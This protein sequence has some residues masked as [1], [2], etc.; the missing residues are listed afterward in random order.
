[1]K[2]FAILGIIASVLLIGGIFLAGANIF[3]SSEE[4]TTQTQTSTS[5]SSCPYASEGGCTASNNCGLSSCGATTGGSC[6]CN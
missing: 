3:D 4:S 5:C 1:M 6:G 2:T